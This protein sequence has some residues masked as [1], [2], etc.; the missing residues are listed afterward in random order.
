MTTTAAVFLRT[1]YQ[2]GITHAFVNWGNDHPA[3]LEEL[4]RQRVGNDGNSDIRIVTC[5]NEMVALSAAQGYAQVAGKPAAVIVH[6]DVGT[7]ALAGAVHNV[8]K[9]RTPVLIFAGGA[10]F[11]GQGELKGS[12]NEWPMWPQDV[13]D[14]AAI[15]RQYM[16][17]T[18]QVLSG[19]I[20]GKLVM[21]ALQFASSDPQGPTYLWARREVME[22]DLGPS[23]SSL[24]L[25]VTKWPL[26]QPGALDPIAVQSI[27]VALVKANFPL[28]ITA[29]AG[30]NPLTIP[31]LSALSH[32][33]GIAVTTSCPSAVCL[34]Y[35][36][37][38]FLGTS[39]AGK[40]YLLEK[41]DVILIL[42]TDVPWIDTNDN[43]PKQGARVFV[44]DPDPLKQGMGWS[45][46]DAE[47]IC[48]ADAEVALNQLYEAVQAPSMEDT[49]DFSAIA[50][51]AVQLKGMHDEYIS[52][53]ETLETSLAAGPISSVANILATLRQATIDLTPSQ[54]QKTLWI[55][56][57]IS[58]YPAVFDHVRPDVP[59]S[60]ICS[61]GTS[62][63]YALGAAIGAQLGAE[64]AENVPELT[65]AVVGDGTFMF[66][67]PSS[68]YWIARRYETPF[69]T[70][71]LNNGGWAS[72]K[73]SMTGL[74]PSGHG[75]KASGAR[76]SVGFG[77]DMPD[78][79]QIAVAAGRAWARKIEERESMKSIIEEAIKIVLEEKRCAVLDCIVESI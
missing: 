6:V 8:D 26:V 72:P 51:R 2:A 32:T 25:D 78:Y 49:R 79:G 22:E 1:L 54:G 42:D 15:V 39:F 12:K 11:S 7:Q 58:N 10:P 71:V 76:L 9:G 21:R 69:L 27:S 44:V 33:L 34:P 56:E 47:L 53:L 23:A 19:R 36:H 55:N 75:S 43:A 30:R 63:G 66:C 40:N 52:R 74:H 45:H 14:Q 50:E 13:P 35:S 31:L 24:T 28:I 64:V 18:A 65:V 16:R 68:A 5:P 62:L 29:H 46:V 67:V 61:G 4:E 3:L 59:G 77:P 73:N 57:A 38:H 41:A 70:I 20:V 60:M 48:R 17:Y 37:P